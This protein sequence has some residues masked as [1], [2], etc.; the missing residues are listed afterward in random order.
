[1]TQ[2]QLSFRG[3]SDRALTVEVERLAGCEQRA[4]A[5][6]VAA[7]AEF[8]NRRL[9]LGAGCSSLFEY[10]TRA[11]HLSEHA[12]YSRIQAARTAT[13]FPVIFDQLSNGEIT[14]TNVG[15]LAPVLTEQ[16]HRELLTDARHRTKRE[17]E[18]MVVGLNP[19]P[20]V[21]CTI[22]PLGPDRFSMRFTMSRETYEKLHQAQD[23]LR[24]VAPRSEPDLVFGRALDAL[25]PL[26]QQRKY[27]R[28]QTPRKVSRGLRYSR[29]IPLDVRRAVWNRDGG[30]CTFVGP[31]GR[32]TQTGFLEFHH[33][34][35]FASGGPSN[36]HNITLR[37][38]AHNQYEADTSGGAS[39]ARE[40]SAVPWGEVAVSP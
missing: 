2:E 17:V 13:R 18:M 14:V 5:A 9:Y 8:E 38:R 4:T 33:V 31:V 37:C 29:Y 11:L 1:M 15:L 34:H 16:N 21:P 6:L 20:D 30:Q 32:C 26:L 25:L 39:V 27:G 24:H 23:L 40:R 3:L 12:A 10:C 35:P 7:L 22:T 28:T 19:R 36:E